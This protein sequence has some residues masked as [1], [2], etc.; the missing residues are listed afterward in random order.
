MQ[1]RKGKDVQDLVCLLSALAGWAALSYGHS[2]VP[3]VALAEEWSDRET[4]SL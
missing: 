2:L 3:E 1:Q 4:K